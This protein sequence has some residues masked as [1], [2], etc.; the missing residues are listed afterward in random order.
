MKDMPGAPFDASLPSQGLTK[1]QLSRAPP[2]S[3]L[4]VPSNTPKSGQ[5]QELVVHVQRPRDSQSL[6]RIHAVIEAVMEHGPDFEALIMERE[7]YNEN[8]AFLFDSN[9]PPPLLLCV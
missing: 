2:P 8:Y 5:K 9:V 1:S 6:R 3:T 7:K 4:I